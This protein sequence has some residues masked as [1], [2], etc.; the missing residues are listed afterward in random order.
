MKR[1]ICPSLDVPYHLDY[2]AVE[3]RKV[4]ASPPPESPWVVKI[5][6]TTPYVELFA[7][8]SLLL[9]PLG[10]EPCSSLVVELHLFPFGWVD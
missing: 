8:H 2:P 9:V 3:K 4:L 10:A 6:A 7:S 5:I 1:S